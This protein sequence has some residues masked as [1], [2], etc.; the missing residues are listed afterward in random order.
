[1][2]KYLRVV[3][4]AFAAFVIEL[5]VTGGIWTFT[6]I[7]PGK[8]IVEVRHVEPI[9]VQVREWTVAKEPVLDAA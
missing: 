1:M 7:A 2:D 9:K 5:S 3:A 4:R 6:D 8:V